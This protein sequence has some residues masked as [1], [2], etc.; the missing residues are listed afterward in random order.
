MTTHSPLVLASLEPHFEEARDQLFGFHLRDQEVEV[1]R[2]GW[3]KHGD[4]T[5]WLVSEVFGLQEAR[6]PEAEEAI[7][8]AHAFLVSESG[9]ARDAKKIESELAALLS[10]LDPFWPQWRFGLER[11]KQ[12][13]DA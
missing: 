5:G 4:A 12:R 9:S 10:S 3:E 6:S 13:V 2:F 1:T 8:R 11:M 7:E